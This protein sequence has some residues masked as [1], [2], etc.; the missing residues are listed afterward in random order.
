MFLLLSLLF[1][2]GRAS[3]TT[4]DLFVPDSCDNKA[5]H[6][7]HVLLTYELQF[8]NAELGFEILRSNRFDLYHMVIDEEGSP[9]HKGI[10]GMCPNNTR[11]I[12]FKPTLARELFPFVPVTSNYSVIDEDVVIKVTVAHVTSPADYQIFTA[13]NTNASLVFDLIESHKGKL[14]FV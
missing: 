7:D 12:S 5:A 1:V 10:I 11:S 8:A 3:I 13:L 2:I 6:L 14:S 9:I 4:E